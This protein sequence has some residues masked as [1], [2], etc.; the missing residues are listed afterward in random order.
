MA[1]GKTYP[2]SFI[3]G[4]RFLW[5]LAF[6][7]VIYLAILQ[8][9]DGQW[10]W[11]LLLKSWVNWILWA[12]NAFLFLFS[13]HHYKGS[14]GY[15]FPIAAL[16][17]IF[18]SAFLVPK[19]LRQ[20][21]I[22]WLMALNFLL[23]LA[24]MLHFP[25]SAERSDMLPVIHASLTQW[26]NNEGLYQLASVGKYETMAHYFPLCLMSHLPAFYLGIDMRW[27]TVLYRVLC[28]AILYPALK[29]NKN[30][31]EVF[32]LSLLY[33]MNPYLNFRHELYF[34]FYLL[35]IAAFWTYPVAQG[36]LL[37]PMLLNR[38]FAILFTPFF[39]WQRLTEKENRN[40]FL[41]SLFVGLTVSSILL[42]WFMS[43]GDWW[44]Y[45]ESRNYL[46]DST[47]QAWYPPYDYGLSVT[48]VLRDLGVR[49]LGLYLSAIAAVAAGLM[50]V[51]RLGYKTPVRFIVPIAFLTI[52]SNFHF[53]NYF[54]I[55]TAFWVFLGISLHPEDWEQKPA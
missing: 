6:F 49:K 50:A 28:F 46:S 2:W 36:A 1:P 33:F 7:G 38:H 22:G 19:I 24:S 30:R 16:I 31:D 21:Q 10:L 54:W 52:G 14:A 42:W 25:L 12:S 32:G 53:W 23:L 35:L 47:G 29:R 15:R 45:W 40:T 20:R 51:L 26:K 43:A 39:G 27:N 3:P 13:W 55:C 41:K 11:N 4:A 37:S 5:A 9:H 44:R 17:I 34:E 48:N 8:K 18:V